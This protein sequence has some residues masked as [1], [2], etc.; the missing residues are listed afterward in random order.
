MRQQERRQWQQEAASRRLWRQLEKLFAT[1]EDHHVLRL[2]LRRR[3]SKT[4]TRGIVGTTRVARRARSK[5]AVA[6]GL[7][8]TTL[9]VLVRPR[10]LLEARRVML[11]RR[12]AG[13]RCVGVR[14]RWTLQRRQAWLQQRQ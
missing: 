12:L 10:L 11:V 7:W 13:K 5:V 9:R 3:Q 1:Q 2:L 6:G 14:A 8:C 4:L